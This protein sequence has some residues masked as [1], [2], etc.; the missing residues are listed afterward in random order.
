MK[1][2]ILSNQEKAEKWDKFKDE[3]IILNPDLI[4]ENKTGFEWCSTKCYANHMSVINEY[5]NQYVDGVDF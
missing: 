3:S 4:E 5:E 1:K 2:Q